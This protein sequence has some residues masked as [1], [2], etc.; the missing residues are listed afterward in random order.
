MA[1]KAPP[2]P[3]PKRAVPGPAPQSDAVGKF[4]KFSAFALALP[5][6]VLSLACMILAIGYTN[7]HFDTGLFGIPGKT[8][9]DWDGGA[10]SIGGANPAVIT[11]F[12]SHNYIGRLAEGEVDVVVLNVGSDQRVN[13]GDVFVLDGA[14]QPDLR[15]EFV[16][17]DLQAN[18]SRAY[19]LMG[20]NVEGGKGRA[21]SLKRDDVTRL[22]GAETNVKVKRDWKNQII[23]RYV[24]ARANKT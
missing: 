24:E 2:P 11:G 13:L 7:S 22:C 1:K 15:V 12:E 20:Q 21:F 16:V 6:T 5:C 17:F 3:A 14:E 9:Q 19:I 8:I 10:H 4:D 23:R 18:V